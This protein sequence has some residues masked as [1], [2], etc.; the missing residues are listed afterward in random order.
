[1]S[2]LCSKSIRLAITIHIASQLFS[3]RQETD[4]ISNRHPI[5]V[6]R[7]RV[8]SFS[9]LWKAVYMLI[10][11][12]TH[13]KKWHHN[14]I[15][16]RSARARLHRKKLITVRN[17]RRHKMI[18]TIKPLPRK[19]ARNNRTYR[20]TRATCSIDIFRICPWIHLSKDKLL[21]SEK[22]KAVK[23]KFPSSNSS[24]MF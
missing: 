10:K 15:P 22:L 2:I 14:I 19:P 11:I 20:T 21:S 3:Q 4:N 1:M 18:T 12:Y 16:A 17:R 9:S 5:L 8:P 6:G 13:V 24:S 7:S 23:L